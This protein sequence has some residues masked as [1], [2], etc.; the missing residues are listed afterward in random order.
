M[1]ASPHIMTRFLILS[2]THGMEFTP[3]TKPLQH[4]DVAI[5]CGDLTDGSKLKEFQSA[6]KLLGKLNA[7]LKL[8]I[9]GNHDFTLDIPLFKNKVEEAVPPLD[10]E[11]IKK[12]YGDYG[13]VNQLFKDA[14]SMGIM[15]LDEG[16]HHFTLKNG[17]SLTVFASPYTPS[18][19]D[20]GFQYTRKVGH[21]F[22][23]TKDV[24]LVMTHG[25]PRGVMDYTLSRQRAGCS[26]LFA[27]VARNRPRMH[28]FGHI[29]EAWGAKLITWRDEIS[30]NP[31]HFTDINNEQSTVVEQLSTLRPSKY[32]TPDDVEE[33]RKNLEK[34][35][36]QRCYM[37][38]QPI[39]L[40]VQTLFV[41][42][43]IQGVENDYP[44]QLPWLV[45]I[46]LPKA[47]QSEA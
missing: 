14:A 6:L 20:W 30:E 25:P 18:L 17:A 34:Y 21:H 39:K 44:V 29:H 8:I 35:T 19:G 27:A 43:A 2:D 26:D 15:L 7:P 16:V 3:E 23:I 13:E 24:D 12:E 11:L 1:S 36:D 31:S 10:P 4:A 45:D 5:H 32:D 9:A 46:D 41:N 22:A 47:N 28:C 40:G 42:A 33:K 37:T 38:S